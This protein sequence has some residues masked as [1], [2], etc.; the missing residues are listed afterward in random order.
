RGN[1]VKA[2]VVLVPGATPGDELIK[3]LQDHV[4]EM[5]APYK[6]P[7]IIEFVDE[8]PKTIGG[9]IKRAQIRATDTGD[10]W[11]G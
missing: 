8:L 6:Y 4:K 9:K 1:V 7:R 3:E 5:T 2:T 11:E 10:T